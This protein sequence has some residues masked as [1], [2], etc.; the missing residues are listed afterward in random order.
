METADDRFI[1]D[2][3]TVSIDEISQYTMVHELSDEIGYVVVEGDESWTPSSAEFTPDIRI[4]IG[5]PS[6]QQPGES[7]TISPDSLTTL[8]WDK[9]EQ[10]LSEIDATGQTSAGERVRIGIIDS[11]VLGANPDRD[12]THPDLEFAGDGQKV[13]EGTPVGDDGDSGPSYNF[14]GDEQGP[15]PRKQG[16]PSGDPHGTESAGTAAAVDNG[17]G[18]VGFAPNAEIVDLRVFVGGSGSFGDI[19]AATVVGSTPTDQTVSVTVGETTGNASENPQPVQGSGCDVLNLSLG[20]SS[21]VPRQELASDDTPAL[22]EEVLPGPLVGADPAVVA[23]NASATGEAAAEALSNGTLPVASAGNSAIGLGIPLSD[24][25]QSPRVQVPDV[26]SAPVTFPAN[27]P[28]YLTV[29]ATGPIGYGW[30]ADDSVVESPIQTELPTDEPAVYSNYGGAGQI[31]FDTGG[32]KITLA[33]GDTPGEDRLSL[34]TAVDVSAGGGNL[35]VSALLFDSVAETNRDRLFTTAFEQQPK[36]PDNPPG[37]DV[38]PDGRF[39]P[40]FSSVLGTSFSAP[41]VS[42]VAALLAGEI[43]DQRPTDD[44]AADGELTQQ[45]PL[46]S[47][48]ALLIREVIEDSAEASSVGRAGETSAP[49]VAAERNAVGASGFGGGFVRV[50]TDGDAPSRPGTVPGRLD[51]AN[52]RG[53]GHFDV[54]AALA[55]LR[56]LL[57]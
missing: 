8:Q 34:G 52:H 56:A 9:R 26:D 39:V 50:P 13:L 51:P 4:D 47:E 28:D 20:G 27:A 12:V 32:D 38:D 7:N 17:T 42:G 43:L 22:D 54:Q 37:E 23:G 53:N 55:R 16:N 19:I 6:L 48:D 5:D 45:D 3:S 18:V 30:P 49:S 41:N 11:G 21:L 24:D 40:N 1:V 35:D 29:S 57:E 44:E 46:S 14:T 25:R 31:E 2:M 33:D 15:G 36:D 10:N